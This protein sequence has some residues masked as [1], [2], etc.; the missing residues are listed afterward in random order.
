MNSQ[1]ITYPSRVVKNTNH[2]VVIVDADVDQLADIGM[3]CS[4]SEKNY[5]IYIYSG[6]SHDL[7]WLSGVSTEADYILVNEASEVS[8]KNVENQTKFGATQ[9][10]INPLTYFETFDKEL[11]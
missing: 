6:K 8:I 9:N 7:E 1:L 10:L 2:T 3:F 11:V 4:V 5:D